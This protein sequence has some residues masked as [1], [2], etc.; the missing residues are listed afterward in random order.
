MP[1]YPPL[2]LLFVRLGRGIVCAVPPAVCPSDSK[3]AQAGVSGSGAW[4]TFA[5]GPCASRAGDAAVLLPP[6]SRSGHL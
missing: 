2:L 3:L 6:R 5:A 4:G 1:R